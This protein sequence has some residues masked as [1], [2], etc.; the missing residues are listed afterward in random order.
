MLHPTE[1]ESLILAATSRLD[2]ALDSQ[3]LALAAAIDRIL[4]Q[5]VTSPLDF[6]HWDNSA[7]D[8]YAVRYADLMESQTLTVTMEIRAG[9]GPSQGIGTGE[10]ARI[11]TGAML[12]LGADTI[13]MQEETT[14]EGNRVTMGKPPELGQFVRSCGAFCQAGDAL[15]P[16]GTKLGGAELAVLAAAQVGTVKV[17]RRLRVGLFSTGDEL[18]GIESPLQPGQIVDSNRMALA[19][20]LQQMGMVVVDFGIVAD[21][22]DRLEATMQ[23]ALDQCD[24]V[25]SS[26]GVSVGDYDYVEGLLTQ[27]GGEIL[28]Q[29]V[30]VKPGKPLTV[31]KFWNAAQAKLYFGLPGNPVSALVTFWRFV[32]PALLKQSGLNQPWHLPRISGTA[33]AKLGGDRRRE[34]Y[35]WG[36]I[37]W[38]ESGPQ[39]TPAG[40]SHSSGNLINLAMNNGLAIVPA[41]EV[42]DQGDQ[43]AI[44]ML[45]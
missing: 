44:M 30:A 18:V 27:L 7:M 8:G 42:R 3:P 28:V 32:R 38:A 13:V 34:T 11:F 29:S 24:I 15:I 43:V 31:A 40:G 22:A 33:T 10:A 36:K 20:I 39:F 35:V 5:G 41:G 12:P 25:I 26:G 21:D 37:N 1:A 14:L 4:A 19:G 23:S 17:W 2:L 9:V 16:A 45:P 6:P